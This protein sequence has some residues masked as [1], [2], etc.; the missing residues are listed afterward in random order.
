MNRT[1]LR[2]QLLAMILACLFTSNLHADNWPQFRGPSF[3]GIAQSQCPT[4]WDAEKNV[5]WKAPMQGEGWSAPV[6]WDGK[7]YLT[8]AV[9]TDGKTAKPE[10]YTN[11][12]GRS[13]SKFLQAEYRW[14]VFCLDAK[15]GQELWW[16]TARKGNPTLPRHA[17]NTY[18]TETPS[19]M[20][21][22]SMPTLE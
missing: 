1:S 19:R 15:T 20:A 11:Q 21:N 22:I 12:G 17:T 10:P 16:S 6:I 13:E 7:V 5:K 8:T 3:D 14:D 18:A 2:S 9:R 4:N